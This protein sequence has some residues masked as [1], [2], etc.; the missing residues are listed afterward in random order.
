MHKQEVIGGNR[1]DSPS[2]LL[3][4]FHLSAIKCDLKTYFGCFDTNGR[5]IGTD[6]KENWHVNEFYDYAKPYFMKNQG[7][8]YKLIQG[9][10]KID[11]FPTIGDKLFCVFDELLLN[12]TFGTCRG[13]GSLINIQGYW[14]IAAYHL[15][16][17]IPNEMAH[18]ITNSIIKQDTKLKEVQ[19]DLAMASLLKEEEVLQKE[20]NKKKISSSSSKKS[21][22]K[23]K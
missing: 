14:L 18:D 21:Q 2:E 20:L 12:D 3:D 1:I 8:S 5:F 17:P 13:T 6:S 4:L 16:F 15:S 10:R 9:S 11:Y 22:S 23:I 7:W 19:S